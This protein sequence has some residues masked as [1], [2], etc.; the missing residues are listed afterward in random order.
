LERHF[1]PHEL[2]C[3]V[4]FEFVNRG[5]RVQERW[6]P[7]V[8]MN[9][10]AGVPLHTYVEKHLGSPEKLAWLAADWRE[11]MAGLKR[12][13][14]GHGDLQHGNVLVTAEG[15][16]K[17]VDYDG[18]YVPLFAR[19]RS[20]ELGHPNYQ[21]PLRASEFY[22]ERLDHFPELLVYLSLRALAAEPALWDEF[23]NGDNLLATAVDLR[24]PQCSG[25]WP[26][27]LLSPDQDVRRLTVVLVECLRHAPGDVPGLEP[28]LS[29]KLTHVVV[30]ARLEF[31][32]ASALPGSSGM[33]SNSS[34]EAE[35]EIDAFV[36]RL[37]GPLAAMNIERTPA[38][39][40]PAPV[41]GNRRAKPA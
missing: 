23:F 35:T 3:L 24:V 28:V 26:R 32:A 40:R 19:E 17:L 8:K 29:E 21:H 38:G 18:V 7:I 27:L 12:L 22:D 39:S 1:A 25:L 33:N 10:V 4:P 16:L 36:R 20:P 15:D 41:D 13:R 31:P 6:F 34:S 2:P 30:P 14:I 37:E 5:I 9:W 11:M